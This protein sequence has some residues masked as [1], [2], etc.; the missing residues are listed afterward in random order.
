M[1]PLVEQIAGRIGRALER[2]GLVERDGWFEIPIRRIFRADNLRLIAGGGYFRHGNHCGPTSAIWLGCEADSCIVS[3]Y[4]G[5]TYRRDGHEDASDRKA[6]TCRHHHH[7]R[8]PSIRCNEVAWHLQLERP[9]RKRQRL[10]RR[11]HQGRQIT[12]HRVVGKDLVRRLARCSCS[13]RTG[14]TCPAAYVAKL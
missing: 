4:H 9:P 13:N 3:E 5:T 14:G 10:E 1:P 11:K 8:R 2:R 12:G 6:S 7:R